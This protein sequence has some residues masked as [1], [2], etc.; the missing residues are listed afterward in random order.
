MRNHLNNRTLLPSKRR[1]HRRLSTSY[2]TKRGRT[3]RGFPNPC[4]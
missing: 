4:Q 1:S 2:F 3:P